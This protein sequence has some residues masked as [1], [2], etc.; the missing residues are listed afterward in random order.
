MPKSL[1]LAII[2]LIAG[3]FNANAQTDTSNYDLGRI[4]VKKDFT[5][6]V[7]IKGADLERYQFSDLTD[8]IKVWFYGTYTN[9]GSVVY[10]VNGNII[11]D[12]NAYSIYDIDEITLVQSALAQVSGAAPGQQLILIKLKTSRPGKQGVTVAGQTS[13]V[14]FK[15]PNKKD[16]LKST[17]NL[18]DQYYISAYKNMGRVNAGVSADLQRDVL[19][20]LTDTDLS[21]VNAL[22][23]TRIKLNGYLN[24]A[25]WRGSSVNL[26][27]NYAPQQNGFSD[28]Y[29]FYQGSAEPQD[30]HTYVGM[31]QHLVNT[32]FGLNSQ[33]AKGLNNTLSVAYSRYNEFENDSLHNVNHFAYTS[34]DLN[35]YTNTLSY[36]KMTNALLRDNLWYDAHIG[37]ITLTPAVNLSYRYLGA[38]QKDSTHTFSTTGSGIPGFGYSTFGT[39]NDSKLLLLNPSLSL[40][41][42]DIFYVQGGFTDILNTQQHYNFYFPV[43]GQT[44]KTPRILSYLTGALDVLKLAGVNDMKLKIFASFAQHTPLLDDP[45][46]SLYS[47]YPPSTSASSTNIPTITDYTATSPFRT[48]V[49]IPST[50][51]NP[52]AKLNNYE[53]GFT[54]DI[55]KNLS[56]NYTYEDKYAGTLATVKYS[57]YDGSITQYDNVTYYVKSTTNRLGLNYAL[58]TSNFTWKTSFNIAQEK[59]SPD[60]N[61]L[62]NIY[63][64]YLGNGHRY[65][66]GFTNR[67]Q[68]KN[69][70]AGADLLYQDG[71]RPLDLNAVN[72]YSSP[73]PVGPPNVYLFSLQSLYL[74]TQLKITH[75]QYAELYFNTRTI[76]QN[77]P[78]YFT[79]NRRFYGLGLK[80][81]L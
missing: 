20:A 27:I 8:A 59:L 60:D 75:T 30:G 10:V 6:S 4:S 43:A 19:P 45:S 74:G 81:D 57:Y 62:T 38:S 63:N 51:Y 31:V 65:S 13:L 17:T 71:Q 5:Q 42:K 39:G 54:W 23:F 66:G 50:Q 41:F 2:L 49:S 72:P 40:N 48:Y 12:V 32:T 26:G 22:H 7:T 1:L 35:T 80:V 46:I 79:D 21:K 61:V 58:N 55:L 64:A 53:A 47:F 52:Y 29:K 11:T 37:Q 68:Y 33:I 78:T 28:A 9:M 34:G 77:N 73:N 3:I 25:L 76:L 67:F 14:N 44:S 16:G 70:F 18:Y 56:I 24:A 36:Q 15:G 69:L